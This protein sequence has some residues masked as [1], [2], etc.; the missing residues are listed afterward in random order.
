MKIGLYSELARQ[1]IVRARSIINERNISSEKREM[2]K[3]REQLLGNLNE[4]SAAIASSNNFFSTSELRDLLF[5]TQEHRFTL[6][7]IS[8]VIDKLGCSFIGFEF[9]DKLEYRLFKEE[10]P[11]SD[12]AYA[13]DKWHE[14]ETRNPNLFRAMYQF[15]MQK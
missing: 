6:P 4:F 5:H 1:D 8:E 7:Q 15:W 14:Y 11:E 13:L 2:L 12:A 3:F 10:Y 9:T